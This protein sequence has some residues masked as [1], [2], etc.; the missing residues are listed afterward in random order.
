MKWYFLYSFKDKKDIQ[1][2]EKNKNKIEKVMRLTF[3][4]SAGTYSIFFNCSHFN[5]LAHIKNQQETKNLL[6]QYER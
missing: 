4:Q 1:N 5:T 2:K 3:F 6:L